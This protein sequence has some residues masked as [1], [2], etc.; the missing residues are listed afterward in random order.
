MYLFRLDA[1]EKAER[2]LAHAI[3][4]AHILGLHR[5][6]TYA[7]KNVFEDEM[8]TRVW[9][10]LY[11]LDRRLALESGRP[12]VIQDVSNDT[13]NPCNVSDD[14]LERH[15]ST[16]ATVSKLENEIKAESLLAHNTAMPYLEAT[17]SYSRVV[18]DVWKAVYG[19]DAAARSTRG[20][21]CDY[22]DLLLENWRQTL[23]PCLKYQPSVPYE[24]QFSNLEWWQIKQCLFI[25]MVCRLQAHLVAE[26]TL[27]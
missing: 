5:K 9:W 17:I 4:S 13:R 22:L 6:V 18:G 21:L 27:V 3:S 12:F 24:G 7:Q 14:W 26:L 15:K 25:H 23:P 8:F 11:A 20:I 1:S 10:C 16:T 2:I 19:A